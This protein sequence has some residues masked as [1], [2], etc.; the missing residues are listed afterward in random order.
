MNWESDRPGGG[1]TLNVSIGFL[2]AGHWWD[3]EQK[4]IRKWFFNCYMIGKVNKF[5]WFGTNLHEWLFKN[6]LND[7]FINTVGTKAHTTI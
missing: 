3:F 5:V 7:F 2:P 4:G 1:Y 6:M